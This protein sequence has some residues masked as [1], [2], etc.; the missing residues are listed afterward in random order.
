MIVAVTFNQTTWTIP[1]IEHL[2]GL[3]ARPS[4]SAM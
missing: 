3:I 4:N 1:R 2:R